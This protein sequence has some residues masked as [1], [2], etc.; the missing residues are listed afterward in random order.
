MSP[1]SH[2]E[3]RL[4]L[5][6]RGTLHV[7]FELA[8]VPVATDYGGALELVRSAVPACDAETVFAATAIRTYRLDVV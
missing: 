2:S 3:A 7:R 5:V 8:R 6:R 4:A 1:H